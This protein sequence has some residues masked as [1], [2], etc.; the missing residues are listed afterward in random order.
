MKNRVYYPDHM[1]HLWKRKGGD[2]F[3]AVWMEKDRQRKKSLKTADKVKAKR[4]LKDFRRDLIA[5]KIKP[6]SSG[7]RQTLYE[8]TEEFLNH[9][10]ATKAISTYQLYDTALEKAKSA[11]GDI[12]L[13]QIT[14][15]HIDRLMTD[16]TR[17]GLSPPSV[18]KNRRHLK[19][20]LAKAYEW[21][22]LK[23]PVRFPK[24]LGEEEKL[25]YLTNRQLKSIIQK[26]DDEEFAD[27]CLF[28]AYTGLR[29]GEIIRLQW[30]DLDS[31]EGFL[32][33]SPKQK[34]KRESWIP[35]NSNARAIL[36]RCR[37]RDNIKPFRFRTRQTLSKKF[38][39]AAR[40]SG[41]GSYRFHDLRHTYG[42]HL[43]M[44]GENEAVIQQLMRHKSMA[45]TFIYTRLSPRHLKDASEKVNY[46]PMLS[47]KSRKR[48]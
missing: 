42:S 2:I 7:I 15:R 33:V 29:S 22:Y 48:R 11:W 39:A 20:A 28:S 44:M 45:S 40:E 3:Y 31:P 27:C 26:L 46:G 14:T 43:A 8:F 47:S 6:I 5:G 10:S 35:I 18:N 41:L 19:A 9:I 32:R 25:R 13:T 36:E 12:P 38:K 24:P 34:N 1:V 21:Q 37:R 17:A 30:K 16:M 23:I 4:R